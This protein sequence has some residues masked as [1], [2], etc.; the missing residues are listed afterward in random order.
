MARIAVVTFACDLPHGEDQ[1]EAESTIRFAWQGQEMQVDVCAPHE[2]QLR[3]A[4]SPYVTAARTARP[5]GRTRRSADRRRSAD[6]RTW[7]QANG[8][9]LADRGRV[10]RRV[11]AAYQAS[12]NGA[13][14]G[15]YSEIPS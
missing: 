10:P 8:F 2:A 9:E 11:L 5:R 3:A 14:A 4:I 12:H 7:G 1:A 13:P 6:V 15:P